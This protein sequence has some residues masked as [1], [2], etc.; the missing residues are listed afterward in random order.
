LTSP[1]RSCRVGVQLW[2]QATTTDALRRAA[3]EA[4]EAG[5]DSVWTWDHFFPLT[6][7]PDA[8]HF[9]AWTLLSAFAV[10]TTHVRLGLLVGCASYRNAHLV[11]DMARTVDHLSHGRVTLGLGAGWFQRDYDEYE[12]PFGTPGTRLRDLEAYL[13]RV[14][15]RLAKLSPPPVGDLP[16]L[17]GGAG[18]KVTLRLVAEYADAWNGYGTPEE[19]AHKNTVLDQWCER[20]ERDPR[21]IERT[22]H[23]GGDDTHLVE[24]YLEVGVEHIIVRCPAPFGLEPAERVIAAVS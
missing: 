21:E 3:I 23:I 11:A 16:V 17:I 7:D 13:Y 6:G 1:E 15:R 9:E 24:Q 20:V 14:R 5:L 8:S 18:E 10:E 22:I 12:I 2:P 4:D 19:F